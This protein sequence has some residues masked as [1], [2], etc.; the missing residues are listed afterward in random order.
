VPW[1]LVAV[2]GNANATSA[3]VV[4]TWMTG[5][6]AASRG[7]AYMVHTRLPNAA[8]SEATYLASLNSDFASFATTYG[9]VCAG[10]A[11]IISSVSGRNYRSTI[12]RAVAPKQNGVSE[13]VNIAA[14][15]VGSLSGVRIRDS[16]GN[17]R[18][19][20]ES[21][22]PGLDDAGFLV[23]RTWDNEAGVYVNRP[24]LKSAEGSDFSLLPHR[25]VM[26]LAIEAATSF[27]RRRLNKPIRVDSATGFIN[28]A[29]A[30]EIEGGL[31][32]ALASVL[33]AKPKASGHTQTVSRTD[34]ILST[35]TLTVTFRVV[36]LGYPETI[37]LTVG[38]TNP[39]L[40][41]LTA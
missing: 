5:L 27:M 37:E 14:L 4:E 2:A 33:M 23:L 17:P 18:H 36:P 40:A 1:K 34:N 12:L 41:A 35:K 3:G 30:A 28:E 16:L 26:E 29:D 19:H 20:D 15:D 21:I 24:R 6:G 8:E 10:A 11:D 32:A 7:R 25:L 13:E 9:A 22:N 39:A 31:R 38:F